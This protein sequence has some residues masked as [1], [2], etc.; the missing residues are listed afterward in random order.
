[1]FL[2]YIFITLNE[3]FTSVMQMNFSVF[4]ISKKY[5]FIFRFGIGIF[6]KFHFYQLNKFI[7]Q[8]DTK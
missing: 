3:V 6:Y 1:M 2:K 5:R 4:S 7:V 8:C